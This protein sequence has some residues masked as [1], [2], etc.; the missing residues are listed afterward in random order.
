MDQGSGGQVTLPIMA[1]FFTKR[2][3]MER[4]VGVEVVFRGLMMPKTRVDGA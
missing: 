4:R 2:A 3:S 1:H